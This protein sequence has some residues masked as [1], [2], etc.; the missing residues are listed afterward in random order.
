MFN[1][2]VVKVLIESDL[3]GLKIILLITANLF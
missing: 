3:H 2:V 1:M